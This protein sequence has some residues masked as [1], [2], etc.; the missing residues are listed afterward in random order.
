MTEE[1]IV[2]DAKI[3]HDIKYAIDQ[4]KQG[5]LVARDGWHGKDL[6][7]GLQLRDGGSLNT[8]P[9]VYML[10][11]NPDSTEPF[12]IPWTCSQSDLLA[13]DWEIVE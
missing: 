10:L 8:E 5:K 11:P 2:K 7:C 13:H 9:Y 6:R 1:E 12:R 4:M 3:P